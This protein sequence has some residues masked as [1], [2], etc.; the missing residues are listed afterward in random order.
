[1]SY[2]SSKSVKK[3]YV[4]GICLGWFLIS[5]LVDYF[6]FRKIAPWYPRLFALENAKISFDPFSRDI[7]QLSFTTFL[8]VPF[9]ATLIILAVLAIRKKVYKTDVVKSISGLFWSLMIVVIAVVVGHM[10]YRLITGIDWNFIKAIENFCEGYKIEGQIYLFNLHIV[11]IK[12]GV[13]AIV[14]LA[15]GLYFYYKE[16]VLKFLIEKVGLDL[17]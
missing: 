3:R 15:F 5:I 10:I 12:S 11:D 2:Y 16:G 9:L 14:G 8:L 17:S 1:M 6:I 7:S 4:I 13:G